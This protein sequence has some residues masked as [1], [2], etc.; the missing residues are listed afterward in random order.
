MQALE[1][2]RQLLQEQRRQDQWVQQQVHQQQWNQQMQR[3]FNT[4]L[5]PYGATPQP[6]QSQYNYGYQP[7]W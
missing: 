5:N 4:Q 2:Q 7:R 6:I 1:N 3:T